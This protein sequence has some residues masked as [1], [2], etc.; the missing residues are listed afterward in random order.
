MVLQSVKQ[1]SGDRQ[2]KGQ[3]KNCGGNKVLQREKKIQFFKI[4]LKIKGGAAALQHFWAGRHC[5][6]HHIWYILKCHFFYT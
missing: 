4:F 6:C 5:M 1:I 2:S 3:K